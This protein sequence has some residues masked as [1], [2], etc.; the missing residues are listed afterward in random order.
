MTSSSTPSSAQDWQHQAYQ[1]LVAGNWPTAAQQYEA[2]IHAEPEL[3]SSY[4]YLGLVLLLQGQDAEAQLTWLA[5]MEE[6]TPEQ[7]EQWSKELEGVLFTEAARCEGAGDYATARMLRHYLRELQPSDANNVLRLIQLSFWD[8]SF[9]SQTLA[10]WGLLE[11]LAM[12]AIAIDSNLLRQV[13]NTIQIYFA[14]DPVIHRFS[15]LCEQRGISLTAP[16]EPSVQ[17]TSQYSYL[18]EE[19]VIAKYLTAMGI[20]TGCCVDIAAGNGITMSNTYSLYNAGWSG[21]AV[22]CD[23]KNFAQLAVQ[24]AHLPAVGL[25]R[26]IATPENVVALLEGHQIP[27]GFELLSLDIDGYDHFVLEKIV[28]QF[29]PALVCV[30]INEKIPPPIK[31]TVQWN[32]DHFWPRNHFFGQSL[33]QLAVLCQE[34]NYALVE[35]HYNNAF[36]IPQEL[37]SSP[38]LSPE[39]A[40]R[41]GYLEKADRKEK[42]PWNHDVEILQTLPPEEAIAF[43]NQLFADYVGKFICTL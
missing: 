9:Q 6:G 34:H 26:C 21:L 18:G 27:P 23:N 5:G 7:F 33:A 16:P 24:Y 10:D 22:E 11:L 15:Q 29:R 17:Q 8:G 12:E 40:Y 30:E 1:N 28:A 38:S 32:R 43:I 4:W 25:S 36:L 14:P 20:T 37:S 13:F 35:L 39:Q 3:K 2:A 19:Q 41:T 31:F 42:F